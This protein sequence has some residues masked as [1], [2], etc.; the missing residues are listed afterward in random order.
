MKLIK[1]KMWSEWKGDTGNK[2]KVYFVKNHL[3][4][5][6]KR[7]S[8]TGAREQYNAS[9]RLYKKKKMKK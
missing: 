9:V 1:P 3:G 7:H 5:I 4:K 6:Y 2:F 8:K